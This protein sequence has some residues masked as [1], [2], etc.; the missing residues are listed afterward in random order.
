MEQN[1]RH[2]APRQRGSRLTCPVFPALVLLLLVSSAAALARTPAVVD[3]ALRQFWPGVRLE[4]SAFLWEGPSAISAR[5]V[6]LV[7][8]SSGEVLGTAGNVRIRWKYGDLLRRRIE[9]VSLEDLSLTVSSRLLDVLPDGGRRSP[10]HSGKANGAGWS[11]GR[12][13]CN[14]G[15]LTVDDPSLSPVALRALFAFSWEEF[16]TLPELRE[17]EHRVVLWNVLAGQAPDGMPLLASL[18]LLEVHVSPTGLFDERKIGRVAC[19]GGIIRAGSDLRGI[20]QEGEDNLAG[21]AAGP[22]QPASA[23]Q[24]P[25]MLEELTVENVRVELTGDFPGIGPG[26]SFVLSTSLNRVPL[27]ALPA[28]L[29]AEV[30]QIELAQIEILSPVDPLVRVLTIHSVFV[31]FTLEGLFSSKLQRVVLLNP[32]VYLSQDLF[33][34]MQEMRGGRGQEGVVPGEETGGEEDPGWIIE[35]LRID[36]GRLVLGG[37]RVGEVGL[38]M[39]FQTTASDVRFDDLASLHLETILQVEPQSFAFP[40]LQLDLERLRGELR[41]AYPPDRSPDNLVNELYLDGLRWRQFEGREMWLAAT[42]DASG[43]YASFGGEAYGGYVNAGLSF[44]FG[45]DSRWVGWVTGTG[46][47]LA[48]LT[49]VLAPKNVTMTG[50]AD[51]QVEVDAAGSRIDRVRGGMVAAA[52]GDLTIRKLDELLQELPR[53][54]SEFKRS[55]AIIALETL[56]D[57]QFDR[58]EAGFWFVENQGRFDLQLPGPRG[59]RKF[60]LFLHADTTEDGR[61]KLEGGGG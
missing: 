50:V 15:E 54:W 44:F 53:E 56:R 9:E 13:Q 12:L 28:E 42:F 29:G 39:A 6:R 5:D 17:K 60:S 21:V 11:I 26:F 14:Y 48:R 4:T 16:G 33:L 32:T 55:G 2:Q 19:S 40:G 51:V 43:V 61:W 36:F 3:L 35:Q 52:P 37:E 1:C 25:W 38:P 58:A 49:A 23:A 47:D 31:Y 41:F 59:S 46:V 57:F 8:R 27:G 18:D 20:M 34:Y 10:G 45:P 7:E 24:T 30:Q 22:V